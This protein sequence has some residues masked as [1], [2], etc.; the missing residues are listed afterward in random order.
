MLRSVP[1]TP[2][3]TSKRRSPT[4]MTPSVT[5]KEVAHR[6]ALGGPLLDVQAG[7]VPVQLCASNRHRASRWIERA[8]SATASTTATS[9]C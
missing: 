7:Q 6:K 5:R 8:S 2:Q 1:G 9:S 3:G 4:T